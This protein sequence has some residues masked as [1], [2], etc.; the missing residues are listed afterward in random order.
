MLSGLAASGSAR[1]HA[2]ELLA[3]AAGRRKR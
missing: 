3:S 1:T 2:S